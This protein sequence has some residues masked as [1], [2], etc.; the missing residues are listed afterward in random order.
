MALHTTNSYRFNL[1]T[2]VMNL[3]LKKRNAIISNILR[4][5]GQSRHTLKRIM[6]MRS[7]DN[8]Y[9]RLETKVAICKAFGKTLEELENTTTL[10]KKENSRHD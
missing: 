9:V 5:S 7:D 10:I 2:W 1:K 6:Y 3:P 4:E 8:T